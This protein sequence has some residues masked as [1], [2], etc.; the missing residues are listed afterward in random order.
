[1]LQRLTHWFP[2]PHA[3]FNQMEQ[4]CSL[5]QGVL[6]GV[7]LQFLLGFGVDGHKREASPTL[8][9]LHDSVKHTQEAEV[10]GLLAIKILQV[11]VQYI[12]HR[13]VD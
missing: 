11:H 12:L 10:T 5:A 7:R 1:M 9:E 8:L 2:R 6:R 4:H 3:V 13:T